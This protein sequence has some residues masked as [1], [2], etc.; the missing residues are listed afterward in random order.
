MNLSVLKTEL[1]YEAAL[2]EIE[3]LMDAEGPD[4]ERLELLVK[5]VCIYEDEHYPI[6]PPDPTEVMKFRK[7]QME[8]T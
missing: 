6:D 7:E 1:V 8:L 4:R 5:Q 3:T 2:A